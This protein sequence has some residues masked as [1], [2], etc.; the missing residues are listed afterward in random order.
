[1]AKFFEGIKERFSH[2]LQK[3]LAGDLNR[4]FLWA[5]VVG[6]IAGLGAVVFRNLIELFQFVFFEKGGQVLA[7]LGDFW[8][9]LIPAAGGLLVGPLIYFL[10]REA[11]GHGVPEV[12][13]AIA[14]EG[15]RIRPR[16]AFVKI[17][18]SALSIGS[19]GSVGREGPIVQIGATCGSVLAQRLKL[20]QEWIRTLVACGAAG[21]ISATFNA[22]IAGVFFALEVILG[23][24]STRH[25]SVVVVTSV[26]AAVTSHA[27]FPDVANLSVPQYGLEGALEL[28]FY[29]ILGVLAAFTGIGFIILLYGTEDFFDAL[30][31]PEYLKPMLGGLLLG[32]LAIYS[33]DILGVGYGA[34]ERAARGEVLMLSALALLGFKILATSIT[35]G[36]G[37]S[38][39]VFA[40]SLFLGAMLGAFFGH[41]IHGLF[42][43]V[44][45]PPGA[46]ALVGMAAVFSA[47]AR[48]PITSVVILFELTRDY[49]IVLP[50]M[51]GVVV[52]TII[53]QSLYPESIYTLKITRKGVAP[54][55]P[56]IDAMSQVLVRDVMTR[57]FPNV[58]ESTPITDLTQKFDASGR[59]GFPVLDTS[60][61]L[62]GLVTVADVEDA[63]RRGLKDATAGEIATRSL[64][65]AF[66]DQTV[67]DVLL[68]LGALEVG[69]IPVVDRQNP[70]RLL[71]ILRRHD[72]IRAYTRLLPHTQPQGKAQ[73]NVLS[74]R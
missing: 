69:R 1:M 45:A 70:G 33:R 36:S 43:G 17:L 11:K 29:A 13:L 56:E 53:A 44:T 5:T 7:S 54:P 74:R 22:P 23:R 6:I 66:P 26:V 12:M 27:F 71:G 24:F 14:Q 18:A 59:R 68:K 35:I 51:L 16:V 65:T 31:I 32:A 4:G 3:G 34:V 38:G 72:I 9:I 19:G 46:Y 60:G 10:A 28:P 52:S 42:P 62:V 57:D 58:E 49:D 8:L 73:K 25:F 64:L 2:R 61:A 40:P 15:G 55:E 39:G 30:R 20:S 37:G 67:R 63:I 48:A 47:A 50:L 21:G 41:G